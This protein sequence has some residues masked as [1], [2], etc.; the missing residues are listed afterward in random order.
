MKANERGERGARYGYFLF[1][2]FS[3][4]SFSTGVFRKSVAC[5]PE[6]EYP[7]KTSYGKGVEAVLAQVEIQR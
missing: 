1:S 3:S 6:E 4:L 7:E 2:F 5:L